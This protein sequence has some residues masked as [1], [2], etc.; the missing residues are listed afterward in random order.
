[1]LEICNTST[2]V[3]FQVVLL[4]EQYVPDYEQYV[5]SIV[6]TLQ[7]VRC[8]N[9]ILYGQTISLKS[10]DKNSLNIHCSQII[11]SHS[12]IFSGNV[13]T[14]FIVCTTC[15]ILHLLIEVNCGHHSAIVT[16]LLCICRTLRNPVSKRYTYRV[17]S[18]CIYSTRQLVLCWIM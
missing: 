8:L 18:L 11:L 13:V 17:I 7:F 6:V 9:I 5:H 15:F 3:L 10:F 2:H 14:A 12:V 4:W 1:M 16:E